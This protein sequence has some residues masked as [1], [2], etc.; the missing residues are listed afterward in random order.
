MSGG[1]EKYQCTI[2]T[3][4]VGKLI[5]INNQCTLDRLVVDKLILFFFFFLPLNNQEV[6]VFEVALALLIATA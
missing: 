5:L 1:G 4:V 6:A 2:D 3:L